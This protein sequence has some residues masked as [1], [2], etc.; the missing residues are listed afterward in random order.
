M[1]RR[2][3]GRHGKRRA[4]QRGG[5]LDDRDGVRT[6]G[7]RRGR[8]L[9][10][11]GARRLH[12]RARQRERA[13]GC[14]EQRKRSDDP[15]LHRPH[16]LPLI[17]CHSFP[18]SACRASPIRG[19]GSV[20]SFG[21]KLVASFSLLVLVPLIAGF[22]GVRDVVRQS[23]TRRVDAELVAA[24]RAAQATYEGTVARS[25]VGASTFARGAAFQRALVH[26]DVP[27]LRA[28]LAPHPELTLQLGKT[29]LGRVP[30][31][32][33]RRVDVVA[34]G[35][36]LGTLVVSVPLGAETL[37]RIVRGA[38]LVP[39]Q[40]LVAARAGKA[41]ASD[42]ARDALVVPQTSPAD[43]SFAGDR[44]RVVA[45]PLGLGRGSLLV[46]V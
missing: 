19:S 29:R 22:L 26:H 38:G 40:R 7:Q 37:Q 23:E 32:S 27:E 5:D 39:G 33:A 25:L 16:P 18:L 30:A 31:P 9:R 11:R 8:T 35:K 46:A 10:L 42:G 20:L 2:R 3:Q 41:V 1:L 12:G 28:L 6:E 43:V 36:R 17:A 4:D 44:F 45:T 34:N 13:A 15:T 21:F 14:H 24:A